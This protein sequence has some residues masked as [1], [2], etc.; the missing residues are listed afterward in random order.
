[1]IF[2]CIFLI[3]HIEKNFMYLN[4]FFVLKSIFKF[5]PIF[6]GNFCFHF[7]DITYGSLYTKI[8]I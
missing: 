1:M 3:V 7:N 6:N 4:I 8:L 5:T 2:F